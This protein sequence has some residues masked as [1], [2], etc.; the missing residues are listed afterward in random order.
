MSSWEQQLTVPTTN[1][2]F[3]VENQICRKEHQGSWENNLTQSVF[4]LGSVIYI[5]LTIS[6]RARC[7]GRISAQGAVH[8]EKN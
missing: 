3:L 6:I 8:T 1:S 5:L 2:E 4:H 7:N